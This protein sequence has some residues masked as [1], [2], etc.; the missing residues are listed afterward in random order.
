MMD[1]HSETSYT[2]KR[3]ED[4]QSSLANSLLKSSSIRIFIIVSIVVGIAIS[5]YF[6]WLLF[7]KADFS[8]RNTPPPR[9]TDQAEIEKAESLLKSILED[10]SKGFVVGTEEIENKLYVKVDGKKWRALAY[11]EK[12]QIISDL[13]QARQTLGLFPRIIIKDSDSSIEYGSYMSH[14]ILLAEDEM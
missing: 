8:A 2:D 6:V 1:R 7:A 3:G 14:R 12:K 13:A 9:S 4:F 5:I 11:K 10:N